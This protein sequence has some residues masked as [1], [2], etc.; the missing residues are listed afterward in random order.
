MKGRGMGEGGGEA[1]SLKSLPLSKS[2]EGDKGG[3]VEQN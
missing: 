2:G 1:P 3:E